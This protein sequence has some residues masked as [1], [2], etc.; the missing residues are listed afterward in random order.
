[1]FS[2]ARNISGHPKKCPKSIQPLIVLRRAVHKHSLC[3]CVPQYSCTVPCFT[4]ASSDFLHL[5][6][7]EGLSTMVITTKTFPIKTSLT[8]L[9]VEPRRK[10]EFYLV[11]SVRTKHDSTVI[12]ILRV[13]M[14]NFQNSGKDFCGGSFYSFLFAILLYVGLF[15]VPASHYSPLVSPLLQIVVNLMVYNSRLVPLPLLPQLGE[16]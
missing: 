12:T 8:H 6:A 11:N 14:L 13:M 2:S 9:N 5:S 4:Y 3:C 16:L 7:S 10:C 15:H 1:M